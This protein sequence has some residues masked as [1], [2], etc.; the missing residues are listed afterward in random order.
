M[1]RRA[2]QVG[3]FLTIPAMLISGLLFLWSSRHQPADHRAMVDAMSGD[4]D[5]L[6]DPMLGGSQTAFPSI[7]DSAKLATTA[8]ATERER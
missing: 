7:N 4:G 8:P 6:H 5:G 3:L 2:W 1:L